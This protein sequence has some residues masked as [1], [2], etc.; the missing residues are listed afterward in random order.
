MD[1]FQGDSFSRGHLK[2][3]LSHPKKVV[4]FARAGDIVSTG[5]ARYSRLK[6]IRQKRAEDPAL[7]ANFKRP[8]FALLSNLGWISKY[9]GPLGS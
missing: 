7:M 6:R 4:R 1:R 5:L 3:P 8:V 2:E 9:I